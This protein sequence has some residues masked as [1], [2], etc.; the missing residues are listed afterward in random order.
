MGTVYIATD[1]RFG[2]TVAVKETI[3]TDANLRRAFEREAQLM[4]SLRHPALPRVSDHFIEGDGQ[5][6]V[7]EY[8]A[9]EDLSEMVTRS[10]NFAVSD[11]LRWAD[12]LLDALNYL[13]TQKMPVIHRD[14]KPQNLKLTGQGDIVLLDFGL[15]K[16]S[17]SELSQLSQTKSVFGYSRAYAPLEQIQGTGTDPRSDL[18]SLAATL[19]H[20]LTGRPPIDALT[21]ATAVLSADADPLPPVHQVNPKVPASVAQVLHEAMALNAKVR[22]QTAAKMRFALAEAAEKPADSQTFV[23]VEAFPVAAEVFTQNTQLMNDA[24]KTS[25]MRSSGDTT[26]D[27]ISTDPT[28]EEEATKPRHSKGLINVPS[29]SSSKY[30]AAASPRRSYIAPVGVLATI[31]LLG[32]LGFA[33][34]NSGL[35]RHA[36]E[37]DSTQQNQLPIEKPAVVTEA[38]AGDE[39]ADRHNANSPNASNVVV[40][41]ETPAQPQNN[42]GKQTTATGLI[43]PGKQAANKEKTVAGSSSNSNNKT[44]VF[45]IEGLE[46]LKELKNLDK[47]IEKEL[48]ELRREGKLERKNIESIPPEIRSNDPLNPVDHEKLKIFID[49]KYRDAMRKATEENRRRHEQGLP[50]VNIP[51][52]PRV[53]VAPSKSNP[54]APTPP[55]KP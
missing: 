46:E 31:L 9:G 55:S 47:E 43:E 33:L 7:M 22:P 17:A 45:S 40:Q 11:V 24:G 2:S 27:G 50:P 49:K 10:G 19:Y 48:S 29:Q 53:V 52:P 44:Q 34:F 20:L 26:P 42:S 41:P 12:Q 36:P 28:P 35:T 8:I 13:H 15:A 4:N 3:F 21:R 37:S 38:K 6:L 18:Y 51:K 5:F 32:G 25:V 14:I 1:Q 39:T 16:G 23:N 30:G 54:P